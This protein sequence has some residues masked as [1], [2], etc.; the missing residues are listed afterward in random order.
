MAVPEKL[1]ITVEKCYYS[2]ELRKLYE[3]NDDLFDYE[4]S[5]D[6]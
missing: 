2:P 4:D 5:D 6:A 1:I 3:S